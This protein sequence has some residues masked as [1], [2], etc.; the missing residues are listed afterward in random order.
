M[1]RSRR[2]RWLPAEEPN[3][4]AAW[5]PIFIAIFKSTYCSLAFWKIYPINP[6]CT[7]DPYE[8]FKIPHCLLRH[9]SNVSAEFRQN[10]PVQSADIKCVLPDYSV[11]QFNTKFPFVKFRYQTSSEPVQ[12]LRNVNTKVKKQTFT[13]KNPIKVHIRSLVLIVNHAIKTCGA[14]ECSA[15]HS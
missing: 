10:P 5:D 8:H 13:H 3:T 12:Q 7:T 4:V 14:A 15:T 9:A 11:A 6:L 1:S 2:P